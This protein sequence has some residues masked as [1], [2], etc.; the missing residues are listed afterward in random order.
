MVMLQELLI[1]LAQRYLTLKDQEMVLH[2]LQYLLGMVME[3]ILQQEEM[4]D[5]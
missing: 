3:K 4:Y 2:L 5:I 1:H